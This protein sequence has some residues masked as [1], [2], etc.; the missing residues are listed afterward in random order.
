GEQTL[1]AAVVCAIGEQSSRAAPVNGASAQGRGGRVG[2]VSNAI[3]VVEALGNVVVQ[4][5]GA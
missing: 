1:G 5:L 3:A 4:A 2:S